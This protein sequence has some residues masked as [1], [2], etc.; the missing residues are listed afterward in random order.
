MTTPTAETP[1]T[2]TPADEVRAAITKWRE[3]AAAA[4]AATTAGREDKWNAWYIVYN[5]Q[6]DPTQPPV[7]TPSPWGP[8]TGPS[9]VGTGEAAVAHDRLTHTHED[10]MY[11]AEFVT[12]MLD[13]RVAEWITLTGPDMAAFIEEMLEQAAD[14]MEDHGAFER[15]AGTA[16]TGPDRRR[17]VADDH[18]QIRHGWTAAL[19][20]ARRINAP[21]LGSDDASDY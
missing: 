14:D 16:L 8:M 12:G 1:A 11:E 21:L 3:R 6:P 17:V 9:Y 4:R 7:T 5:K 18:D 13:T 2:I 15:Y 19:A 20:M 10:A